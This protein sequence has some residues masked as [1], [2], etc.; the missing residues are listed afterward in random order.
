MLIKD[1]EKCKGKYV[2]DLKLNLKNKGIVDSTKVLLFLCTID[3]KCKSHAEFSQFSNAVLFLLLEKE[4]E[5]TIELLSKYK[6]Q[7]DY[8][9]EMIS[10]PVNDGIDLN[11]VANELM[12]VN[13]NIELRDSIINAIPKH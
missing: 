10:Q 11:K 13:K 1:C 4:P 3:E 2:K 8:I 7:L 5:L 6:F 9:L 12:K